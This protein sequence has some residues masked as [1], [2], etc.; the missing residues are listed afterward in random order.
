[1]RFFTKVFREPETRSGE[2]HRHGGF[3]AY[4]ASASGAGSHDVALTAA[5]EIARSQWGRAFAAARSDVLDPATA[6]ND[7]AGAGGTW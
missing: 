5:A 3:A 2:L 4:V 7:R 1:M 6:R